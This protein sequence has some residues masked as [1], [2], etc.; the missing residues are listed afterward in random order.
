[1]RACVRAFVC[2]Y[3]CA[4]VCSCICVFLSA[5]VYVCVC[6][7]VGAQRALALEL[8]H[9]TSALTLIGTAPALMLMDRFNIFVLQPL[10][11]VIS[12]G[13]FFQVFPP[14]IK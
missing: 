10:T 5:C 14:L 12:A 9:R 4:R 8:A 13:F 2:M 11:N 1:M 6:V 7:C 3:V